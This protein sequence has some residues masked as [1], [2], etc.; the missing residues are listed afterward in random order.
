MNRMFAGWRMRYVAGATKASG[1]LFCALRRKGDDRARWILER[2]PKALLV[3]NAF[4]YNSGHVMVAVNRHVGSVQALTAPERADVWRLIGR[5]EKA[6]QRVYRPEGM[7]VGINLGRAAGAGVDGHLHVHVVPR[8]NGDTN[9]M[10]TVGE[11]RVLPE[12]LTATYDRL[13]AVLSSGRR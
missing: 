2:G 8:W 4:P 3:L 12:D 9:F 13:A 11:T 5:V 6:I 1:C 10:A 7:N